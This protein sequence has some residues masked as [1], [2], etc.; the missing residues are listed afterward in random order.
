MCPQFDGE[1]VESWLDNLPDE[2]VFTEDGWIRGTLDFADNVQ[3]TVREAIEKR[4]HPNMK[5]RGSSGGKF[6][7]HN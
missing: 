2:I 3:K 7:R 1:R 6:G 5:P 4:L